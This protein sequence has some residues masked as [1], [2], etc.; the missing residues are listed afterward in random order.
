M[1]NWEKPLS[2]SKFSIFIQKDETVGL[3][4]NNPWTS[5][6]FASQNF[7]QMLTKPL[8]ITQVN[9]H[10]RRGPHLGI[11]KFLPHQSLRGDAF[12]R[13]R[14]QEMNVYLELHN[15]VLYGLNSGRTQMKLILQ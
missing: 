1:S 7:P 4:T 10:S 8:H 11:Q 9:D 2:S 12:K 3:P 5:Q 15:L 14:F 6:L 13:T